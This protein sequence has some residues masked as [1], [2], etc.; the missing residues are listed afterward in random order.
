MKKLLAVVLT[1]ILC[2]VAL[3]EGIDWASMT[4]EEITAIV[5]AGQAE[6]KSRAS[7]EQTEGNTYI[8]SDIEVTIV[9]YENSELD[10][11]KVLK[12]LLDWKNVGER[13]TSISFSGLVIKAYQNGKEVESVYDSDNGRSEEYMTGYGGS[14]YYAFENLDDSEMTIYMSDLFDYGLDD[15]IFTVNP[16]EL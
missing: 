15:V 5:E 4:D 10:G 3:A 8:Y 11:Q 12:V 14:A 2:A 1:L 13:P 6:L 9:G 7:A 16:S